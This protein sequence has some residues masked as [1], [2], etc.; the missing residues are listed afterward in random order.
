MPGRIEIKDVSFAKVILFSTVA[1]LFCLLFILIYKLYLSSDHFDSSDLT[2]I[3]ESS[4]T[5]SHDHDVVLTQWIAENNS[6]LS[7]WQKASNSKQIEDLLDTD[8]INELLNGSQAAWTNMANERVLG[9]KLV[10]SKTDPR[11]KSQCVST[12]WEGTTQVYKTADCELMR[13]DI[14]YN[15]KVKTF[16]SSKVSFKPKEKTTKISCDGE[17]PGRYSGLCI[18]FNSTR[19]MF[20]H[21]FELASNIQSQKHKQHL[22]NN[23]LNSGL[24]LYKMYALHGDIVI[25]WPARH[26]IKDEAE[27]EAEEPRPWKVLVARLSESKIRESKIEEPLYDTSESLDKQLVTTERDRLIRSYGSWEKNAEW[28][29]TAKN[30]FGLNPLRVVRECAVTPIYKDFS[31]S[32][33]DLIPDFP[34]TRTLVCVYQ[35]IDARPVV[36]AFDFIHKFSQLPVNN[37]HGELSDTIDSLE[38][39]KGAFSELKLNFLQSTMFAIPLFLVVFVISIRI[40]NTKFLVLKRIGAARHAQPRLLISEEN[41]NMERLMKSSEF[42]KHLKF[43]SSFLSKLV[44]GVSYSAKK[45]KEQENQLLHNVREDRE[46]QVD[47]VKNVRAES[48]YELSFV[49]FKSLSVFSASNVFSNFYV[50]TFRYQ[51]EYK[52]TQHNDCRDQLDFKFEPIRD[53]KQIDSN[54]LKLIKASISSENMETAIFPLSTLQHV[55]HNF[56]EEV[57]S[58]KNFKSA[59]ENFEKF[60][61]GR[62]YFIDGFSI[63][64]SLESKS[65]SFCKTSISLSNLNILCKYLL[66]NPDSEYRSTFLKWL[67]GDS[68]SG[69]KLVVCDSFDKFKKFATKYE[70]K[71]P[72]KSLSFCSLSNR[73]YSSPEFDFSIFKLK[74]SDKKLVVVMQKIEM[75]KEFKPLVDNTVLIGSHLSYK[76]RFRGYVTTRPSDIEYFEWMY[77]QLERNGLQP[78]FDGVSGK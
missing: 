50:P 13:D 62:F 42:T 78:R 29:T 38:K 27:G 46:F 57:S 8:L 7:D 69:K 9:N 39:S 15:T 72:T 10:L 1:Y 32:S 5:L 70:N 12:V 18:N 21:F 61:H 37:Y 19:V 16:D 55:E 25:N 75:C 67:V 34:P 11:S 47:F 59:L 74:S 51:L 56:P 2:A 76:L 43:T 71:I 64:Q 65:E 53:E 60:N 41:T 35:A 68:I 22:Y 31:K 49:T 48:V 73:E 6:V 17:A 36:F 26:S 3:S 20:N 4:K 58:I 44:V 33:F 24:L 77:D 28:S 30:D 45:I 66:Q 23:S 14:V 40:Q 63:I 54:L 52:A